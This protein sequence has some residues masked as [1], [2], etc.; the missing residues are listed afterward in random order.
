MR[1]EKN[2]NR[3]G[4]L[5]HFDFVDKYYMSALK[6]HQYNNKRF[7]FFKGKLLSEN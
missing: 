1:L 5:K 6:S 3:N 2:I 7:F 4:K